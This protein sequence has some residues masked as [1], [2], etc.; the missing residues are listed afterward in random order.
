[1]VFQYDP[2]PILPDLPH[3]VELLLV[4]L[5]YNRCKEVI[6]RDL[7]GSFRGRR[8]YARC[9]KRQIGRS[10]G[11]RGLGLVGLPGR[12]CELFWFV[13]PRIESV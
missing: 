8:G 4:C 1:M 12:G 5:G 3:R 7:R 10:I 2:L 6:L 13:D 11:V 9:L